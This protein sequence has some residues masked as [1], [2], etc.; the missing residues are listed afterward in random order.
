MRNEQGF[1]W[2]LLFRNKNK[3]A[4]ESRHNPA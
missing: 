1:R 2:P 3:F 4:F